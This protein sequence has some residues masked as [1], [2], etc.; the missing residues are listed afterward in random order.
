MEDFKN[1]M[2]EDREYISSFIGSLG[3]LTESKDL[4]MSEVSTQYAENFKLIVES[5]TDTKLK[6]K[7]K[8]LFNNFK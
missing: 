7:I 8:A 6:S 4:F 3:E 5:F 2:K 1:R